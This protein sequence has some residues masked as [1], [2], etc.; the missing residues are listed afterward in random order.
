MTESDDAQPNLT[1]SRDALL[2]RFEDLTFK[3]EAAL[4]HDDVAEVAFLLS[5]REEV[6]KDLQEIARSHPLS[7]EQ[8]RKLQGRDANLQR[9]LEAAQASLSAEAGTARVMGNAARSYVKNS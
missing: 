7:A 2:G 6:L 9:R 4:D 3:I 8:V 5:R 1:E